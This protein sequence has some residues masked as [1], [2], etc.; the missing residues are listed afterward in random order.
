MKFT[1]ALSLSFKN[2]FSKRGRTILTSFAGSIGI[3]GIALVLSISTGFTSYINQLQSDALGGN[4]ITVSTAT[5]DY[6]K[7]A[8]F[9][10][11]NE[12]SEG[13]DNNYITVYEGSFQKYVKYGHYN[14][15]SQNLLIM[16]R[17]LSKKTLKE[18]RTRKL[19]LFNITTN[20][21]N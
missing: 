3:I 2:L 21:P 4:P 5:I 17:R 20:T 7:L 14:Y 15:I 11:E 1:T 13:G 8:S 10:V 18:K 16:L 6:T 9:E 12:S 19:V